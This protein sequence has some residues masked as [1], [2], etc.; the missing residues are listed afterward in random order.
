MDA[1]QTDALAALASL[2][3]E[4][5]DGERL[6]AVEEKLLAL[7]KD[8]A[9]RRRLMFAMAEAAEHML[10]NPKRAFE[11]YRRAYHE[12]PDETTLGHLETTAETYDLWED[13]ISVYLGEGART[14]DARDHVEVARKVAGLCEER[15]QAPARAFA[16]LREALVHEP[17]ATTLLPE[18]E[19]LGPRH[20]RLAR[21]ARCLC[22][23]GARPLGTKERIA[24]LR[25]RAM[26]RENDMQDPSGAFDEHMRAFVLDPE[27]ETSHQ[28]IL[29]LAELTGRWE[30]ALNVEGQ[31][32]ARAEDIEE[33]I[34]ISRRAADLVET[35]IKDDVRAF[36]A[37]LGAFR[38]AP[39]EQ[40]ITDCLWRLAEKI[41]SYHTEPVRELTPKPVS[42]PI[43]A[44]T[45][46]PTPRK[47]PNPC[48]SWSPR[49]SPARSTSSMWTSWRK[50]PRPSRRPTWPT[51]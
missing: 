47:A 8:P 29:R 51:R 10:R 42:V 34:W 44:P 19:R 21:T 50:R 26:V 46:Q 45:V 12:E 1:E 37:Y 2:H 9:E 11:W 16:V 4:A 14:T 22:A 23:G 32:F 31:L 30:D 17:E 43:K 3:T 40:A 27:S 18:L 33:K 25:Q 41:G 38:L 36:R 20:R 48:S 49:P 7:A 6:I 24:L 28:E 5:Q 13:L 35:K 15:L 39:D